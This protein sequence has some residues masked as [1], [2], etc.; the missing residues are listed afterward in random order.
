MYM[1][2]SHQS[3]L[4]QLFADLFENSTLTLKVGRL[5]TS[6]GRLETNSSRLEGSIPRLEITLGRPDHWKLVRPETSLLTG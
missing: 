4:K 6:L 5:E 3:F 2:L 1:F